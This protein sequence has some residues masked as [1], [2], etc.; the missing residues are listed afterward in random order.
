[1]NVVSIDFD[2]I[3]E[4]DINLYNNW[5]GTDGDNGVNDLIQEYSLLDH[6]KADLNIY[7]Y[8]TRFLIKV[9]KKID[10]ENIYFIE[11]HDTLVRYIGNSAINL[12]N[13]DHHHDI[14]Y[15]EEN[16]SMP[17]LECYC[18]NWI[19]YLMDYK[20]I[21]QY[22][23]IKNA[24]SIEPMEHVS[25][26]Y[27][28]EEKIL[29]EY[30]L[31]NLIEKIDRLFICKSPEWIPRHYLPLFDAWIAICEEHYGKSFKVI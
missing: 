6:L 4:P 22:T 1:M 30:N 7:E 24:N 14:T 21:K 15:D 2:I 23:W 17:V 31:D 18:G 13:I 10:Y 28:H 11:N 5:V 12:W 19:K 20:K 9:I 8:L 3:M 27:N 25:K 29:K 26:I 16:V